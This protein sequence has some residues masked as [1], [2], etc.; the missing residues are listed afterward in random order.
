VRQN[1]RKGDEWESVVYKEFRIAHFLDTNLP[2]FV[3]GPFGLMRGLPPAGS[4][5]NKYDAEKL[6][7]I[8]HRIHGKTL[9]EIKN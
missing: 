6:S 9:N 5:D 8:Q 1:G 3:A 4:S 2:F 7:L